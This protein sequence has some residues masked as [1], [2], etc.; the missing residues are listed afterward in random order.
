MMRIYLTNLGKYNEGHLIG[1]WVDLP[2]SN[3]ELQKVLDRIGI[4]EEYEEYFI[5]DSE[6]DLD[7]IE[8]GEYSNLDDLNEMAETLES[9][10][11]DEKEVVDAIMSEGYSL[12][13]ALKKKDD[14]IVYCDC[15]DMEDVAREYAEQTGLPDSIP[16]NLQSY[17][18][19]E[20]YG[21]DMSYEGTFV[22]TNNGNCVQ[23]L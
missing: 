8:I 9:L 2:I 22:F 20:A 5:T 3:E 23:I 16:E 21:R 6:T 12:E 13:E 7:G 18:D 19:F 17:F 10:D 11:D 4:N 14:C 1:E 15:S